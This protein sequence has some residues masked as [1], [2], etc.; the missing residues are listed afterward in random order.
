MFEGFDLN[1]LFNTAASN[2]YMDMRGMFQGGLAEGAGQFG[3]NNLSGTFGSPNKFLGFSDMLNPVQDKFNGLDPKAM[4]AAADLAKGP[5]NTQPARPGAG[6]AGRLSAG[7]IQD[8]S[9]NASKMTQK[10]ADRGGLGRLI[11]GK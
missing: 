6:V 1:S 4:A 9:A 2:P 8:L 11:Y 7:N 5:G 3:T 10:T